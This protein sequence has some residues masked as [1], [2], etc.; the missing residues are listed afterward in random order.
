ME[1]AQLKT[2]S[3]RPLYSVNS[4]PKATDPVE[5]HGAEAYAWKCLRRAADRG[6]RGRRHGDLQH[7]QYVDLGAE[8]QTYP[9]RNLSFWSVDVFGAGQEKLRFVEKVPQIVSTF[10]GRDSELE[11]VEARLQK[12]VVVALTGIA[13]VG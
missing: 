2:P 7:Q 11:T 10:V 13:G 8:D 9:S 1:C 3:P 4:N 5:K 6:H 12:G